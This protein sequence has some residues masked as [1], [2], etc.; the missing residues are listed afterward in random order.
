MTDRLNVLIATGKMS[1]EHDNR[2]RSF[3]LHGELLTTLLESTGRFRVRVLEEFR[4]IGEEL[5]DRFD[6]ALIN[7]EGRRD[8]FSAPEGFGATTDAALLRFVR[9]QGRGIVWFHS[10]VV[11]DPRWDFPSAFVRMR[12][13]DLNPA[14]GV[15]RRPLSEDIVHTS[16]PRHPI[17]EGIPA[18]WAV[19]N[20]DMLTGAT[21]LPGTRV[22]LTVFDSVEPYRAANWPPANVPVDIP[23]GGIEEL[24]GMN[25]HQPLAWINDYG[26]G[27]SFSMMLGHDVD[28]FR[29]EPFMTMLVRGVEW[30]GS[31]E[32]TLGPPARSGENRLNMW[33]YYAGD[34][35]HF[36]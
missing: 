16:E 27:R 29:R 15:R 28:T 9:E 36:D 19:L 18:Q 26:A 13:V 3:R 11:Q 30:A 10:S 4:G 23:A 35:S 8:Y 1:A 7:Y 17:S 6:V 12:G 14:V 22:L 25:T 2:N 32:V 33:P 34:R 5:L 31:G 21:V 24:L 20:D